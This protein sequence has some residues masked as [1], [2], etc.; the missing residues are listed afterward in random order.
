MRIRMGERIGRLGQL[1]VGCVVV[2]FDAT[3]ERMLLTRRTDNG[4]WCLPGGGM[5]AGESIAEACL[6]ELE[7]ETGARG[8]DGS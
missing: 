3:R 8:R 2:V 5:D 7:E 6:R 1:R 4:R